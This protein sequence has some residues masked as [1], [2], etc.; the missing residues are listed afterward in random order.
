MACTAVSMVPW[1]VRMMTGHRGP[2]GVHAL[3]QLA[4]RELRHAEVRDDE[5][6]L[7]AAEDGQRLLAV[8]GGRHLVALEGERL[9][10]ALADVALVV[11]DQD[12]ELHRASRRSS[13]SIVSVCG[14]GSVMVNVVPSPSREATAMSPKCSLT[15]LN[16]MVSPSPV[17]NGLVVK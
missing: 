11:D 17:P 5:V 10:E 6:H 9:G 7:L 8:G 15:I 14:T 3:Q 1:P 4:A 12:G 13:S 16:T 2:P